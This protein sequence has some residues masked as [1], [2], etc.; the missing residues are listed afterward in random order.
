M[1]N[2]GSEHNA[3]NITGVQLVVHTSGSTKERQGSWNI[4]SRENSRTPIN[5]RRSR[6]LKVNITILV[7]PG[8]I[9]KGVLIRWNGTVEWNTGME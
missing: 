7:Q 3:I 1:A 9:I 8:P 5:L 4:A 6:L 2:F